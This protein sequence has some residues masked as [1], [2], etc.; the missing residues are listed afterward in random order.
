MFI[1]KDR[2]DDKW[3]GNKKLAILNCVRAHHLFRLVDSE[4][5]DKIGNQRVA[6][7]DS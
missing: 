1:R 5:S 6:F 7:L 2:E 3:Y 4:K